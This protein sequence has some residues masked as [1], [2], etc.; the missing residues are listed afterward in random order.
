MYKYTGSTITSTE[1]ERHNL[2]KSKRDSFEKRIGALERV[3]QSLV[4]MSESKKEEGGAHKI[5][6]CT[7]ALIQ[8]TVSRVCDVSVKDLRAKGRPQNLADARALAMDLCDEYRMGSAKN[9][10]FAFGK[11]DHTTVLH[12]FK[13]AKNLRQTDILFQNRYLKCKEIIDQY[14]PEM[15]KPP[16]ESIKAPP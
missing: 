4:R 12:A 1:W 3:V 6:R 15:E 13:K 8:E 7:I 10:G 14:F 16:P 9:I 2:K 5:L 11:R